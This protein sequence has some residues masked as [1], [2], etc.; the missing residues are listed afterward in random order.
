MELYETLLLIANF[1]FF[2][3]TVVLAIATISYARS[4]ERISKATMRYAE[5]AED[6]NK[7]VNRQSALFALQMHLTGKKDVLFYRTDAYGLAVE[8]QIDQNF[9][10]LIAVAFDIEPDA[11]TGEE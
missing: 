1:L 3:A 11:G 6:M 10:K 9:D 5:S 4:T 7:I 8:K 2:A